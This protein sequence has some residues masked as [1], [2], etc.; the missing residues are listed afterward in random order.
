MLSVSTHALDPET[1]ET[2]ASPLPFRSPGRDDTPGRAVGRRRRLTRRDRRT[3]LERGREVAVS[4]DSFLSTTKRLTVVERK[5]ETVPEDAFLSTTHKP[6]GSGGGKNPEPLPFR[7]LDDLI[8]ETPTEP[9]WL[10]RGFLVPSAITLISGKPKV[11]KSS[12]VAALLPKLAGGE[13]FLD[14]PTRATRA[15]L[16]TEESEFTI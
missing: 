5:N 6:I 11:G 9:P 4:T 10:W 14:L 1:V 7:S 3:T 2:A 8:A 15:V 16:L 13:P 12:L